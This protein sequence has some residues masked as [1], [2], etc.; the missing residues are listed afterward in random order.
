[1][2][3]VT[4]FKV[5]VEVSTV[6]ENNGGGV[7]YSMAHLLPEMRAILGEDRIRFFSPLGESQELP[8][9]GPFTP[10]KPEAAWKLSRPY[11]YFY[12]EHLLPR[13]LGRFAPAV[14]HFPDAK[15]PRHVKKKKMAVVVTVHDLGAYAG[16]VPWEHAARHRSVLEAGVSSAD[17]VI[18]ISE[19]TRSS[20]VDTLHVPPEK[21]RTVY[22]GISPG[23]EPLP[24][25]IWSLALRERFALEA[26]YYIFVGEV[27]ERKNLL[28]L[29]AAHRLLPAPARRRHPL[30]IAG[31]ID[32]HASGSRAAFMREFLSRVD[33][34]IIL[35]G[36]VS[37]KEKLFLYNGALAFT[38]PS[39]YEGFGL[40]VLEAMACG[41]AVIVL[42][43]PVMRELHRGK[44]LMVGRDDPEELAAAL[45]EMENNESGRRRFEDD[46]RRHAAS[47]T[48]RRTA[49]QT[50]EAYAEAL[51]RIS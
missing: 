26:G 46:G 1:M 15:V 7:G 47:F 42:A 31:R 9:E 6:F 11:R 45:S 32:R 8:R 21:V 24:P 30:V 29:L 35:T 27:N 22:Y 10:R 41:K 14:A 3:A 34:H 43:N 36:V 17:L 44:A 13:E 18:A 40:P 4:D 38:F 33:E 2:V 19:F 28:P 23:Y 48:W 5:A 37:E 16:Q 20:L 49:L 50:I 39:R 25:E 12:R 51:R